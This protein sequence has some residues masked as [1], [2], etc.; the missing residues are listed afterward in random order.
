MSI[1]LL[2]EGVTV[3][4]VAAED[5]VVEVLAVVAVVAVLAV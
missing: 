4:E 5:V 3:E 2:V 1:K